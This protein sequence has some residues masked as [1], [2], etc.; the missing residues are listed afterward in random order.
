M[1]VTGEDGERVGD[2]LDGGKGQLG[3]VRVTELDG[4][5]EHRGLGGVVHNVKSV[6]VVEGGVNVE[7]VTV[8]KVPRLASVGL[9]V[10]DEFASKG[11]KWCGI[12]AMGDVEVLPGGDGR[13]QCGLAE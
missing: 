13:I 9:V 2:A 7:A 5:G 4:V 10:D 11:A 8:P 6:V 1:E 12:V 3:K